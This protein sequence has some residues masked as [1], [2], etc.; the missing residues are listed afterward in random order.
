[1]AAEM[2]CA[3]AKRKW[4]RR[5]SNGVAISVHEKKANAWFQDGCADVR[6]ILRQSLD[7]VEKKKKKNRTETASVKGLEIRDNR[8]AQLNRTER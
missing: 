6:R 7:Q 8:R 2:A 5:F 3:H 1:V 4:M